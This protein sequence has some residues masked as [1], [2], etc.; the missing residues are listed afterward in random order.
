MSGSRDGEIRGLMIAEYDVEVVGAAF[1]VSLDFFGAPSRW[2]MISRLI[3]KIR[4]FG[5]SNS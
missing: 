2:T 5:K 1:G 4:V 3:R